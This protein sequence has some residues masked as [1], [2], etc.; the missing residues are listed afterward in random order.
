[1]SA[2]QGD[3]APPDLSGQLVDDGVSVRLDHHEGGQVCHEVVLQSQGGRLLLQCCPLC[4][5][6]GDLDLVQKL[7]NIC[8]RVKL[9]QK[10]LRLTLGI[11]WRF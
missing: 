1:M 10:V 3:G 7:F 5:I 11:H 6:R 9:L 4:F 8:E 2:G